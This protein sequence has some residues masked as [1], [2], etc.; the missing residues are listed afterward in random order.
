L[1][2]SDPSRVLLYGSNGYTA[3]LLLPR[4]LEHGIEVVLAGR[5]GAA[6]E[7]LGA[8]YGFPAR[9]FDLREPGRIDR[10]LGDVSLVLNAAGPFCDTAPPLIDACLRRRVD[11]LD[12]SGE[13]DSIAYAA[14]AGPMAS[15]LGVM[16]LPAIGFDVAASDCLAVHLS[17]KLPTARSLVLGISPSNLL[18]RGSAI[19]MA[20]NAGSFVRVRRSGA[21]QSLQWH[22]GIRRLDFGEGDRSAV[23]VTWGDLV[24]AFH[25][26][27]IP[28]I[29]VYFEATPL[30][31]CGITANQ[32][33]APLWRA[34]RPLLEEMARTM[35]AG[36]TETDRARERC[37]VVAEVR[38]GDRCERARLLTGEAYAFTADVAVRVVAEVLGGKRC[39]GFT[40]P[41]SLLGPDF[42]LHIA[43]VRRES[44]Q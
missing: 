12:L 29:E 9:A 42:V 3:R 26:T 40:T 44:M 19:T 23:A 5:T 7:R 24:T 16:L 32:L 2:V 14:S 38:D 28:D 43:G 1:A 18:S 20:R 33:A 17:R 27:H 15:D 35:R 21:L 30:W 13:V 6:V 39:S 11:Y 10:S 25:S 41:A 36:P 22:T 8:E 4:L 34:C 31:L 37:I